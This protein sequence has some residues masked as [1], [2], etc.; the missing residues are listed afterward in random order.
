MVR[1]LTLLLCSSL[2]VLCSPLFLA[3]Q[4]KLLHHASSYL[5]N[6]APSP[7]TRNN[8]FGVPRSSTLVRLTPNHDPA[9]NRS[10]QIKK[11][12]ANKYVMSCVCIIGRFFFD[13]CW[14]LS[15]DR[16]SDECQ[17]ALQRVSAEGTNPLQG[18]GSSSGLPQIGGSDN[19]SSIPGGKWF[20]YQLPP[21]WAE[22]DITVNE[23][24]QVVV[25]TAIWEH[26]W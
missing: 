24:F 19:F 25:A 1:S 12:H 5:N 7:L 9:S 21:T 11:P 22:V 14:L 15:D 3:R 13:F 18:L 4:Q 17:Q 23:V 20:Q 26:K 10:L 16:A 2:A 8:S 6:R